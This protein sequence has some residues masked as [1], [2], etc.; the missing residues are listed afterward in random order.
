MR[1]A[2]A[3]S[4][5]FAAI[6]LALAPFSQAIYF[7]WDQTIPCA[8]EPSAKIP[9]IT[10]ACTP[11]VSQLTSPFGWRIHPVTKEWTHHSG[12]DYSCRIGDPVCAIADGKVS[13]AHDVDSPT[14]TPGAMG[15]A[16]KFVDVW[17]AGMN[18]IYA[19]LSKILVKQG[20]D[21]RKG[22]ILGLCG[23]TGMVTGPHLHLGLRA[24]GVWKDPRSY[25][26]DL[27]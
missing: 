26:T 1:T 23:S 17:S 4:L 19:H 18:V 13:R 9:E 8:P 11:F 20:E 2:I 22:Q 25:F 6:T 21:V 24:G 3:S 27:T 15:R 16:G 5:L 7:C 12:R 14:T 10:P